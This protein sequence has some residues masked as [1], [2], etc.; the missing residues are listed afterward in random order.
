M[1]P[2]MGQAWSTFYSLADMLTESSECLIRLID[3]INKSVVFVCWSAWMLILFSLIRKFV[4]E[5]WWQKINANKS[6]SHF[7]NIIGFKVTMTVLHVCAFA[8][9]SLYTCMCCQYG[10]TGRGEWKL[11]VRSHNLFNH[12]CLKA[13]SHRTFWNLEAHCTPLL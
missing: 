13:C 9:V 11:I 7:H 3:L 2:P 12:G 10:G 6:F 8:V 5:R 4:W 1:Q